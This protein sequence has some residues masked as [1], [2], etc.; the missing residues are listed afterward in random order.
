MKNI[1]QDLQLEDTIIPHP[2]K[3]YN[4]NTACVDWSKTLTTKGLRH[5]TIRENAVRES[6]RK[7]FVDIHH[8]DGKTNLSDLFTKE[9]RDKLHFVTLR[10]LFV[11]PPLVPNKLETMS[12]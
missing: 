7:Q 2:I 11:S 6:T 3:L 12:M 8:I 10:D 1:I 5:I 4:D 9:D